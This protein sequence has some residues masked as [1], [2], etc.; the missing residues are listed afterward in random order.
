M[1]WRQLLAPFPILPQTPL[2]FFNFPFFWLLC[3]L[4][5]PDVPRFIILLF[6]FYFKNFLQLLVLGSSAREEFLVFSST[7]NVLISFSFFF[8]FFLFLIARYLPYNVVLVAA[9]HQHESVISTHMFPPSRASLLPP[10]PFHLSKLS[11]ST[12]L[13]S[14]S[15]RENSHWLSILQVWV[16]FLWGHCSFLL[17]PDAQKVLFVPSKSLFPQSCVSSGSSMVGLMA[18]SSKRAYAIPRLAVP[19]APASVAGHCWPIPPQEALKHSK[20]GLAQSLW[21]SWCAQGFVRALWAF[22]VGMGFDPKCDF[23]PPT[24]LLG[25]LLCPWTWGIFSWWDPTFSCQRLF[26]SKL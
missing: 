23:A 4:F 20:A 1:L 15:H 11:Q 19:R 26:I 14:L 17:G 5:L 9:I 3:F 16:S 21:V 6:S 24:I 10:N 18:T 22:L 2:L 13:S 7:E 12:R 8:F 25:L